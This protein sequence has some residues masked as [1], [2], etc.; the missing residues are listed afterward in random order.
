MKTAPFSWLVIILI[1]LSGIAAWIIQHRSSPRPGGVGDVLFKT[2]PL[3]EIAS[4]SIQSANSEVV[5]AKKTGQWVVKNRFDYRADFTKILNFVEKLKAARIGREFSAREDIRKRLK[6]NPP[7]DDDL[8]DLE[9][10][11][12][13]LIKNKVG[14]LLADI[15]FGIARRLDSTGVPDSHYILIDDS[16]RVYLIDTPFPSLAKTPQEWMDAPTI[17]APA[18]EI[19]RIKCYKSRVDVPSYVFERKEMGEALTPMMMSDQRTLD[20]S[21]FKRLEWALTYLPMGDVLAPSIDPADIGL[22]NSIRLDYYLFNGVIYRVFPYAPCGEGKPCY[23]KFEVD[24]QKPD[25]RNENIPNKL[26]EGQGGTVI[27]AKDL[28]AK[29]GKWIYRISEAHHSNLITD[30]DQLKKNHGDRAS[31]STSS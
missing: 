8:D 14:D 16:Q 26:S 22:S 12:R 6:L 1:V 28:N 5:L 30:I 2:L 20:E 19:Q 3:T 23:V 21:V 27:T 10:G 7:T 31:G 24:Y 29:I 17:E 18:I 11:T 9:E 13:V 4:I 15:L 25:I